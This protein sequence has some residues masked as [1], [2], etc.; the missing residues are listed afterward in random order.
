MTAMRSQVAE[1]LGELARHEHDRLARARELAEQRVASAPCSPRR[2][3]ASARRASSTSTS[4]RSSRAICDLLLVAA[5]EL[6]HALLGRSCA[7]IA[8]R[9]IQRA[10]PPSRSDLGLA[11]RGARGESQTFS[12]SERREHQPFPAAI[13][14]QQADSRRASAGSTT[15]TRRASGSSPT[16]MRSSSVRPGAD[17]AGDAQDLAA[18]ERQDAR[19]GRFTPA[20]PSSRE[21]HLAAVRRRARTPRSLAS[22]ARARV[23][24]RAAQHL[25][26]DL[27]RR[28]S[29]ADRPPATRPSRS[30]V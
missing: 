2:C 17:E 9:S 18:A 27:G 7:R 4:S 26:D 6:A 12:A 10:A 20:T 16:R 24:K 8:S 22:G 25:A 3:R 28:R 5:R 1:E 21:H 23:A 15:V 11:K 13:L 30:T 14:A 19:F 29:R